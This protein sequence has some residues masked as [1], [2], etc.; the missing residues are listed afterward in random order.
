VRAR[1][2]FF[3]LLVACGGADKPTT[4]A[5]KPGVTPSGESAD[6]AAIDRTKARAQKILEAAK[7]WLA[8]HPEG[9]CPSVAQLKADGALEALADDND[10][11]GKPFAIACTDTE[12]H[13]TSVGPDGVARSADDHFE[14]ASVPPPPVVSSPPQRTDLPPLPTASPDAV[15][16]SPVELAMKGLRP[17][18][19]RC[20]NQAL[21]QD[22]NLSAKLA[23]T[24]VI[25]PDGTVK[26]A[27]M[28]RGKS[29]IQNPQLA[30]CILNA[31][32][33]T[34]FGPTGQKDDLTVEIP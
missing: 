14:K 9:V 4:Q 1:S 33:K 24:I 28:T 8:L 11:W 23:M 22:P 3:V 30:A 16:P 34:N 6:P 25:R 32:S 12:V 17:A 26:S 21:K 27:K 29:D 20:Y 7:K 18:L 5:P 2:L 13:V 15:P 31:V 10:A 19:Q